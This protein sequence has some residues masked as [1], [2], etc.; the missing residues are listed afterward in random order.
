M[1][2]VEELIKSGYKQSSQ[3]HEEFYARR[4][5]I[6]AARG[7]KIPGSLKAVS[8]RDAMII[9]QMWKAE[10]VAREMCKRTG[11][12]YEELYLVACE[13]LVARYEAFD[14]SKGANWSTYVNR[15]LYHILCNWLRDKSFTI[16]LPRKVASDSLKLKRALRANPEADLN[17]IAAITGFTQQ[18]I[19]EL[20]I[21]VQGP[22]SLDYPEN[23]DENW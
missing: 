22:L 18:Y 11:L 19:S 16:K 7:H 4:A 14:P 6:A 8:E 20:E 15:T 5:Q 1:T 12:P 23:E 17:E 13:A 9:N 10:R 2:K 3:E 21:A